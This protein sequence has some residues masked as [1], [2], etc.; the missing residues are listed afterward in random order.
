MVSAQQ[1]LVGLGVAAPVVHTLYEQE[2]DPLGNPTPLVCP[3]Y[4]RATE[5]FF[6]SVPAIVKLIREA[7]G[8]LD[9][10][11]RLL[12]GTNGFARS[13][14]AATDV[15]RVTRCSNRTL[16][17]PD[18]LIDRLCDLEQQMALYVYNNVTLSRFQCGRILPLALDALEQPQR[19]SVF[20]TSEPQVGCMLAALGVFSGQG[21]A[22]PFA[23]HLELELWDG[24]M[25]RGVY[26]GRVL[27]L[28][29]ADSDGLCTLADFRQ[30]AAK[31]SVTEAQ[32]QADCQA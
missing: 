8:V 12:N 31:F 17:V 16:N 13:L 21:D 15:L 9:E 7:D 4:A 11:Q 19:C 22:V 29:C 10:L 6:A 30:L 14:V 1:H 32:W 24:S 2:A 20:V 26:N 18:A 23:A 3:A 5:S 27:P 28:S 25:V